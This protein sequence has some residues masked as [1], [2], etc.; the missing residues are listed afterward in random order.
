MVP[1]FLDTILGYHDIGIYR[2]HVRFHNFHLYLSEIYF[3]FR[4]DFEGVSVTDSGSFFRKLPQI[5]A[6]K[7]CLCPAFY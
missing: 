5:T 2:H 7:E 6:A 4:S 3:C 1:D